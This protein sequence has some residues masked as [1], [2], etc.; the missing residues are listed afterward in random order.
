MVELLNDSTWLKSRID[1]APVGGANLAMLGEELIQ[2]GTAEQTGPSTFR[3]SRL[4]RGRRGSEWAMAGH[5]LGERF[6]ADRGGGAC[7][8]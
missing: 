8:S 2:F 7:P 5:A 3:L 4:L 6:R 1:A